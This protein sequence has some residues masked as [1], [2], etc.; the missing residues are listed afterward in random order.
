VKGRLVRW[1]FSLFDEYVEA[2]NQ[3]REPPMVGMALA[4]KLVF[5]KV[6]ATL[7]EKLGGNMR[8]FVSGGAPL[9]RK[10]AWFFDLLGYKVLEGYGPRCRAPR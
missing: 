1:A 2:K 3:G 4:R 5:S 10:I 7:D 9:S 8:L 6:R